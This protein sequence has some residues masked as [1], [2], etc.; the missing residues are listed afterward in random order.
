VPKV[1]LP[2]SKDIPDLMDIDNGAESDKDVKELKDCEDRDA[3]DG[4]AEV[5]KD[6]EDVEDNKD[7]EYSEGKDDKYIDED[8]EL[9]SHKSSAVFPCTIRYMDLTC[10]ELQ[11]FNRVPQVL[12]I[13]DEWDKVVDIFNNRG[14]G[15]QGSAVLTGQSGIGKP[16][17]T[18]LGSAVAK[19]ITP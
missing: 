19:R 4:D 12:L 8:A 13:R 10:L 1:V 18:T 14:T 6:D 16:L 5:D 17:I 7:D 2:A 9:L 3:D 11:Y 15:I